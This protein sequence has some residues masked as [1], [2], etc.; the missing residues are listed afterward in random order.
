MDKFR[1]KKINN[2]V[3]TITDALTAIEAREMPNLGVMAILKDYRRGRPEMT[4]ED[5][6]EIA[7][8]EKARE[9]SSEVAVLATSFD[10]VIAMVNQMAEE[11]TEA[12]MKNGA[13][14]KKRLGILTNFAKIAEELIP[15][16][17]KEEYY[18]PVE[19]QEYSRG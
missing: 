8:R 11:M 15:A 7:I 10:R 18:T 13:R 6:L 1:S 12:K 5:A 3:E 2:K 16:K 19:E 9:A 14:Y 4:I 17:V